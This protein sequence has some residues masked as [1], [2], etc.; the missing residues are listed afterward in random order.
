MTVLDC[1][2]HYVTANGQ[3]QQFNVLTITTPTDAAKQFQCDKEHDG[4]FFS[5]QDSQTELN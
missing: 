3:G 5:A 1:D 2:T 4:K